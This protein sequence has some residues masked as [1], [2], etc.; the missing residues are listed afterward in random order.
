MSEQHYQHQISAFINDELSPEQ[1]QAVA[2]HCLRCETCRTEHDTIKRVARLAGALERA[3]APVGTWNMIDSALA[4]DPRARFSFRSFRPVTIAAGLLV[5]LLTG[6][7]LYF[8]AVRRP[9]GDQTAVGPKESV[10][11]PIPPAPKSVAA[12]EVVAQVPTPGPT[13]PDAPPIKVGPSASPRINSAPALGPAIA[14]ASWEVETIAGRPTIANSDNT[15]KLV[16]GE[17]L[18]TDANSRARI[19]VADIGQVEVAPNSRVRLLRSDHDGHRLS[20][21]RGSLHAKIS[22]PP[23]LFIVDTPS[24]V[25]VD[26]GCEYTLEVDPAGNSKLHVTAGFVSLERDGRDALVPAGAYCVTRR[27]QGLGT[28]YFAGSSPTFETA[29]AKFDFSHGGSASLATIVNEAGAEDTLTLWHLLPRTTGADRAKVFAALL[30]FVEL[31]PG[32]S[33][34]GILKLDQKMLESWR[35]A[36]EELWFG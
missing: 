34:A 18:E 16:V 23:R 12:P 32:V 36:M 5:L 33:R 8:G 10:A 11:A 35:K 21:D 1:R 24:A 28:P 22:A 29:L 2:A 17:T 15:D 4:L 26:L 30:S 31:P 9:H 20:L 6:T 27:G 19:E 13:Q 7:A 14:K 3:D 25:A